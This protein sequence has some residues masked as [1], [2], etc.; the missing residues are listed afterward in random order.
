MNEVQASEPYEHDGRDR[1]G[2][3]HREEEPANVIISKK[4]G[5]QFR[6]VE[7][8]LEARPMT[9]DPAR[10]EAEEWYEIDWERGVEPEDLEDM[11]WIER[12]LKE[13]QA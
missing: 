2:M 8:T 10:Q 11:R 12:L 9:V 13:E 5:S 4:F 3:R 7:G 6:Y 1:H